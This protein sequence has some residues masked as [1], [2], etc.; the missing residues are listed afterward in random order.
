MMR[1]TKAGRGP[2]S[3]FEGTVAQFYRYLSRALGEQAG[4]AVQAAAAD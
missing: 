3:P 1:S 4:D 2:L